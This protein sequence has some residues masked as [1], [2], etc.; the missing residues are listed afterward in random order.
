VRFA[1][2]IS[3]ISH[4]GLSGGRFVFGNAAVQRNASIE[5]CLYQA[6]LRPEFALNAP[7]GAFLARAWISQARKYQGALKF[8]WAAPQTTARSQ[9][10]HHSAIAFTA[11]LPNQLALSI[12][13]CLC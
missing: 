1:K 10:Q 11:S 8:Q 7:F 4:Y 3:A 9:N 6:D 2:K 5:Y 13:A 12:P